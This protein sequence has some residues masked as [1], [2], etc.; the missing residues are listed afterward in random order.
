VGN[1]RWVEAIASFPGC[2]NE[3]ILSSCGLD[4]QEEVLQ[5]ETYVRGQLKWVR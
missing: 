3:D 5:K 1:T 2:S 4:L